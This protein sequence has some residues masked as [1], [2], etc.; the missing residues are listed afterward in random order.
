MTTKP[1]TII[2]RDTRWASVEDIPTETVCCI[3]HAK[4]SWQR[5]MD[6]SPLPPEW[7]PHHSYAVDSTTQDGQAIHYIKEKATF[8]PEFQTWGI[9]IEG[10]PDVQDTI[11]WTMDIQQAHDYLESGKCDNPN[12][13]HG[14]K[15]GK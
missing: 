10:K 11:T 9:K 14:Q 3:A 2:I 12:R 15:A 5:L 13:P 8:Y 6:D 1:E 7:Q 4:E